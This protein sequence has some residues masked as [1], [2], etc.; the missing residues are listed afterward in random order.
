MSAPNSGT[1]GF[2]PRVEGHPQPVGLVTRSASTLPLKP[3]RRRAKSVD[4]IRMQSCKA[5]RNSVETAPV[6]PYSSA[7]SRRQNSFELADF[8]HPGVWLEATC[9]MNRVARPGSDSQSGRS[10]RDSSASRRTFQP[11]FRIRSINTDPRGLRNLTDSSERR[12]GQLEVVSHESNESE[13]LSRLGLA[14]N[15]SKHGIA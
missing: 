2:D 1:S 8:R 14:D 6:G 4:V 12:R 9:G 3:P 13:A 15:Q 11:E 10:D 7:R 5:M